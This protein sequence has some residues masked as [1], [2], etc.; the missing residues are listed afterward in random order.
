M[1]S[2]FYASAYAR[3]SKDDIGSSIE[4][5][6]ELIREYVKSIPDIEIVSV[7]EDSGFSGIDFSRPDFGEMMKD[8][9]SGKVNCVIVKEFTCF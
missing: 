8:I 1:R 3:T 7:R 5:Q 2:I 6:I 9:E 4:N